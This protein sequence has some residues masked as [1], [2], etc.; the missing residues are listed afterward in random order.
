MF[1]PHENETYQTKDVHLAA[2]LKLKGFK[3][4]VKKINYSDGLFIFNK[5]EVEGHI[6]SFFGSEFEKFQN[7]TRNLISLIKNLP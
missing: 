4:Q 7:I 3:C 5:N 6:E 2:F 1:N